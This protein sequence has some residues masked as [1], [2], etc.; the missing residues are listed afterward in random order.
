MVILGVDGKVMC[1]TKE[2]GEL[3]TIRLEGSNSKP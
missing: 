3:Q 1:M 2:H